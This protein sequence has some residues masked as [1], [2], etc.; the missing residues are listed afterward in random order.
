MQA[1]K[2][3]LLFLLNSLSYVNFLDD[4]LV[5]ALAQFE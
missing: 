5:H 1:N 3:M 4:S 2:I